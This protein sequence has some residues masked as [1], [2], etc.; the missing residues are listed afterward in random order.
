MTNLTLPKKSE[1]VFEFYTDEGVKDLTH[2]ECLDRINEFNQNIKTD[3]T[4]IVNTAPI[5]YPVNLTLGFLGGMASRSYSVIPGNYNFMEMLKLVDIQKSS[6]FICED[7]ITDL[8]L[9]SDKLKDVQNVTKIVE[10]VV[11]FTNIHNLKNKSLDGFRSLF[12][13]AKFHLYDEH[14]FRKLD[15]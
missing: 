4:N 12:A 11:M 3:Y 6:V 10:H 8:Q 5:F 14:N 9:A 15:I 7:N 1:K 13:N 2:K